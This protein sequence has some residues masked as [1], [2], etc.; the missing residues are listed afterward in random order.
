MCNKWLNIVVSKKFVECLTTADFQEKS[1][2]V[3]SSCWNNSKNLIFL[4]WWENWKQLLMKSFKLFIAGDPLK[5]WF[6]VLSVCMSHSIFSSR[7][8]DCEVHLLSPPKIHQSVAGRVFGFFE[9]LCKYPALQW[10][11]WIFISLP[12]SGEFIMG[13]LV[14]RF[15]RILLRGS[16]SLWL[17]DPPV[18]GWISI[19]RSLVAALPSTIPW[20]VLK[21]STN[22]SAIPKPCVTQRLCYLVSEPRHDIATTT[23]APGLKG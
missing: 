18:K 14:K 23:E 5:L 13:K 2:C 12:C 16:T 11:E 1:V 6:R 20:P 3:S 4:A 7:Q 8:A 10:R 17:V 22:G 19:D 15:L 21:S 9:K